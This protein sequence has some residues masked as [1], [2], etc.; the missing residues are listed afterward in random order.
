MVLRMTL[1]MGR[2][3]WPGAGADGCA[4]DRRAAP[5]HDARHGGRLIDILSDGPAARKSEA[6]KEAGRQRGVVDGLVDEGTLT[7]QPMPRA[8][9][10]PR[11]RS[12]VFR[13]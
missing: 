12:V 6:A 9:A 10:P 7:T 1:R 2:T 11:A 13:A 4:P 8:L 5:A 3:S